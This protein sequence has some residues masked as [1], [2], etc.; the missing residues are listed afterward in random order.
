MLATVAGIS[1]WSSL[2]SLFRVNSSPLSL[3]Y[4]WPLDHN[5]NVQPYY[6]V[7]SYADPRVTQRCKELLV[8]WANEFKGDSSMSALV[9]FVEQL[10]KD[11]ISF[12]GLQ[13]ASSAPP[14]SQVSQSYW[15]TFKLYVMMVFTVSWF[16]L[17]LLMRMRI[18]REL[19]NSPS[20]T[21]TPP[22]PHPPPP[23]LPLPSTPQYP[24][25][26]LPLQLQRR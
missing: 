13:Q 11:G 7:Q 12:Q 18:S 9:R 1:N 14:S 8:S 21:L 24:P 17:L 16:S 6:S 15:Y 19:S 4:A 10:R 26:L 22:P 2:N 20:V 3:G 5:D 25:T 23:P